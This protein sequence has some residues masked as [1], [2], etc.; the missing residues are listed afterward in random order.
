MGTKAWY[1]SKGIWGTLI[2]GLCLVLQLTGVGDVP[3]NE[4]ATLVDGIT[5]LAITGGEVVGVIL[6]FIG[7][8]KATKPIV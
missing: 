4:Q 7:R 3:A 5:N 2:A 6:A 1:Q 8:L